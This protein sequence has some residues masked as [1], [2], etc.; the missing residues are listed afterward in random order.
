MKNKVSVLAIA[1][2][3]ATVPAAHAANKFS[4]NHAYGSVGYTHTKVGDAKLDGFNVKIG[5]S[6]SLSDTQSAF[7]EGEA[8][9]TRKKD[10]VKVTNYGVRGGYEQAFPVGG[11]FLVIPQ[12]DI[13]YKEDKIAFD[14]V[15]DVK[16]K[17]ADIGI[18]VRGQTAVGNVI[19]MP[20]V[21]YRKDVYARVKG[22]GGT[23]SKD[24][25]DT[26]TYGVSAA[27]DTKTMA[28]TIGLHQKNYKQDGVDSIKTTSVDFGV[29]F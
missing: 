2:V 3:L 4:D 14:T 13:G 15:G 11:S 5:D 12:A 25:G 16:L 28:Y 24:K 7:V 9:Q 22:D 23:L 1:A 19:V 6:V 8:G 17:R 21:G 18:G 20:E 26:F 29:K 27:I 10:G